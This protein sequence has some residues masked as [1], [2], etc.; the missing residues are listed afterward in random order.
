MHKY[1]NYTEILIKLPAFRTQLCPPSLLHMLCI[2]HMLTK[3]LHGTP[4]QDININERD[5]SN[6]LWGSK[7]TMQILHIWTSVYP[8]ALKLLNT[9]SEFC[10]A[11]RQHVLFFLRSLCCVVCKWT[12]IGDHPDPGGWVGVHCGSWPLQQVLPIFTIVKHQPEPSVQDCMLV[13]LHCNTS[14]S[15]LY[16][17]VCMLTYIVTPA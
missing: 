16:R 14:L 9:V 11:E 2:L 15:L 13:D 7:V 3:S 1:W 6:I 10:W 4:K 12:Y 17:T 5:Q 8:I